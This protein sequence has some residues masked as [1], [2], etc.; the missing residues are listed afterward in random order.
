ME[1]LPGRD[2]DGSSAFRLGFICA[3]LTGAAL[4]IGCGSGSSSPSPTAPAGTSVPV[5][6]SPT[7]P[8]GTSAPVQASPLAPENS[9][10]GD[11]PDNQ[12]FVSYHSALGGYTLQVPEGWARRESAENASFVDKFNSIAVEV[13][14]SAVA[15]TVD[16]V[17]ANELPRLQQQVE[18][19][20]Q[21][22]VVALDLPAG[23]AIRI[24]YRSNSAADAVT[25]KK[26]RLETDRYELF[27]DGK[28]AALSLSAP[29]GSD[30]VDVWKQISESFAWD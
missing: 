21:V 18:A 23:K 16:S 19:F 22:E 10:A 17:T 12:A 6:A 28:T 4:L 1:P 11:I 25:G 7:A 29:A 2:R 5:R 3:V 14:A 27:K 20:E 30:N 13:T 9:P 24:R 15:P 8:A 26:V